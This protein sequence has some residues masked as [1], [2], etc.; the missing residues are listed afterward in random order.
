MRVLILVVLSCF[1]G[2]GAPRDAAADPMHAAAA[3]E[4]VDTANRAAEAAVAAGDLDMFLSVYTEHAR[5]MPQDSPMI[6]TPE[7]IREFWSGMFA[8]NMGNLKLETLT[9][10]VSDDFLAEVGRVS[11]TLHPDGGEGT[12]ASGKFV[13][14]WKR[15]ADGT[16]G[17]D[18]DCFN[19][20]VPP[21]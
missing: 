12:N 4:A 16:W 5:V 1:M 6:T 2:L 19:S 10:D 11:F 17:W 3:R 8:M 7:G 15:K 9:L 18:V 20:S 14:I 13:M 21:S